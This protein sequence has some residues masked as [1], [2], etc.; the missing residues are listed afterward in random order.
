MSQI[1]SHNI[2][3]CMVYNKK[4][5]ELLKS[6]AQHMSAFWE[7]PEFMCKVMQLLTYFTVHTMITTLLSCTGLQLKVDRLITSKKQS[8]K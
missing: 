4:G 2:K 1:H 7:Q 8:N 5:F 6:E 3:W